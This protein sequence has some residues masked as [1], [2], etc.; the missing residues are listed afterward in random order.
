LKQ[1]PDPWKV[2]KSQDSHNLSDDNDE[3]YI[4][5]SNVEH[6][7]GDAERENHDKILSSRIPGEV[8]IPT[9]RT[10]YQEGGR[11]S[12]KY[13]SPAKRLKTQSKPR[14]SN[15]QPDS[16]L[17]ETGE[18]HSSEADEPISLG[19]NPDEGSSSSSVEEGSEEEVV[20]IAETNLSVDP[21]TGFTSGAEQFKIKEKNEFRDKKLY[22]AKQ[23]LL[24][25]DVK[26]IGL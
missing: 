22:K 6:N 16:S 4:T 19:L 26:E 20:R 18:N 25:K 5:N 1:Q 11:E 13:S 9:T 23:N 14:R 17:Q 10:G 15:S 2:V 3:D 7:F 24:K 21:E 8:I 12:Q